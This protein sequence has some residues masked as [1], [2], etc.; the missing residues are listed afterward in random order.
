MHII[1]THDGQKVHTTGV[2][3]VA[4]SVKFVKGHFT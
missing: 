4:R 1:S 3:D 2:R